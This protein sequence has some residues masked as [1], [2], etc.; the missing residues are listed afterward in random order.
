MLRLRNQR[1]EIFSL[2]PE[3]ALK[4]ILEERQ[5]GSPCSPLFRKRIS[6]SLIHD[7]GL[8]DALPLLALAS[9]RQRQYIIDMEGWRP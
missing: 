8:N 3:A 9:D 2:A 4:R 5:T 7:I 6:I 1:E